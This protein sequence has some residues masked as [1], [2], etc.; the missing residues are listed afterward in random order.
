[1]TRQ[2]AHFVGD[3]SMAQDQDTLGDL[4]AALERRIPDLQ[5]LLQHLPHEEVQIE[6]VPGQDYPFGGAND[7]F[8]KRIEVGNINGK[9]HYVYA[10]L[11]KTTSEVKFMIYDSN[12]NELPLPV[13][14]QLMKRTVREAAF[15][16]ADNAVKLTGL[17]LY[18]FMK[19]GVA[20]MVDVQDFP[21]AMES[22]GTVAKDFQDRGKESLLVKLRVKV[23]VG[24]LRTGNRH[25]TKSPGGRGLHR[26]PLSIRLVP[27]PRPRL[28]LSI[29]SLW[30]Y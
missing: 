20:E 12:G 4:D 8:D 14:D 27:N 22:L 1:M 16:Y 10:Y 23:P 13:I 9:S 2:H 25:G 29:I 24:H 18:Y 6:E 26:S 11:A 21:L 7:H 19:L 5:G 3:D 17:L 28:P 30:S 15:E